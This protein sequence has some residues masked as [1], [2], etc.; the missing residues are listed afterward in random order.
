[1]NTLFLWCLS[2][3]RKYEDKSNNIALLQVFKKFYK[4]KAELIKRATPMEPITVTRCNVRKTLYFLEGFGIDATDVVAKFISD[5][6][7][8]WSLSHKL[9][10]RHPSPDR[11]CQVDEVK[12]QLMCDELTINEFLMSYQ[13]MPPR[14]IM[15]HRDKLYALLY[16][17]VTFGGVVKIE[18]I[19]LLTP[20]ICI[21][22]R[23]LFNKMEMLRIYQLTNYPHPKFSEFMGDK[24][25]DFFDGFDVL[26][27]D[28][29]WRDVLKDPL[30]FSKTSFEEPS[31]FY[32]CRD[33]MN[34]FKLINFYKGNISSKRGGI[35][36]MF[37]RPIFDTELLFKVVKP[38]Y[39]DTFLNLYIKEACD[40]LFLPTI[41][42][43]PPKFFLMYI[44]NIGKNGIHLVPYQIKVH[45]KTLQ[46]ALKTASREKASNLLSCIQNQED[47]IHCQPVGFWIDQLRDNDLLQTPEVGAAVVRK[48][49]HP[50]MK[51][52][53]NYSDEQIMELLQTIFKGTNIL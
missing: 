19:E 20:D 25:N 18:G 17:L 13:S 40:P 2:K 49:D 31:E 52:L 1:M 51:L 50:L 30:G 8:D 4:N 14:F 39:L 16:Y 48:L 43:L 27:I 22:I 3:S 44:E 6:V 7:T 45:A 37:G 36:P 53:S 26:D 15:K 21:S 24:I 9:S 29:T 41:T 28:K 38:K 23:K 46:K 32:I 33:E 35:I 5:H 11:A 10:W 42:P 47:F 34:Y 12:K